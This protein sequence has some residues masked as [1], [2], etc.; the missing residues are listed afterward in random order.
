MPIVA[1]DVGSVAEM[2]PD[3]RY[4]RVV[5]PNSITVVARAVE[6]LLSDIAAAKFDPIPLIERH[7]SLFSS[8]KMAERVEAVYRQVLLNAAPAE[9]QRAGS[10]G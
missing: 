9:G 1:T 5:P 6:S 3:Q 4:G 8:E 7:R 10:R 2:L